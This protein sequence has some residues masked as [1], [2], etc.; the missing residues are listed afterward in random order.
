MNSLFNFDKEIEKIM[1]SRIYTGEAM[2]MRIWIL[3]LTLFISGFYV[4][5]GQDNSASGEKTLTLEQ[6]V[7]LALKRNSTLQKSTFGISGYESNVQTSYGGLLPSVSASGGWQWTRSEDEGGLIN[8]GSALINTPK[9]TSEAKMWSGRISSN[10]TLFDGLSNF[11]SIRKSE[12][13]L[14]SAKHSLERL[15]QDIVFQTISGYYSILNLERLVAV[16]QENLKWN[17]KNFEI[18][19]E[20]SRLGA[21]TMADVYAQQ[22]KLGTA[23]L[24]LLKAQ[25]DFENERSNYLYYLGLDVLESYT[26]KDAQIEEVLE[27]GP[28]SFNIESYQFNKLIEKALESRPDLKSAVYNLDASYDNL[29]MA[30]GSYY[31]SLSNTIA[32]SIKG[33]T[34]STLFDSKQ[35]TL[36]LSL[37]IPIFQGWSIDNRVQYAKID[38]KNSEIALSDMEREIKKSIQKG[39][40]D[41]KTTEKRLEVSQSNVE[42]AREN[43]KIEEEKYSLGSTTLLNVLIANA[44]YINAQ[45]SYI[46][47]QFEYLRLKEEINYYLGIIDYKK[48]E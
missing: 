17:Q 13:E 34:P 46:N 28:E 8:I 33:E 48:F 36:G 32:F 44:D 12:K 47:S 30:R 1:K 18:I 25:N 10:W 5:F 24:E 26:L 27:K 45:T 9:T 14:E 38:A 37:S 35:Y 4:S 21:G 40:L 29:T 23:E 2:R 39:Y 20:K 22:V 16:K 3:T 41:L 6:A 7:S 11:A 31:P 15:K 19:K 42:A 43:L